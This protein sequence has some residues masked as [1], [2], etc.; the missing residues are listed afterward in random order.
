MRVTHVS[1]M[2]LVTYL[3]RIQ[4]ADTYRTHG[5]FTLTLKTYFGVFG[6]EFEYNGGTSRGG[7]QLPPLRN[8]PIN[9]TQP[10]YNSG[11]DLVAFCNADNQV[12]HHVNNG[13]SLARESGKIL[14]I[15]NVFT[16]HFFCMQMFRMECLVEPAGLGAEGSL[17]GPGSMLGL[18]VHSIIEEVRVRSR[19]SRWKGI[20]RRGRKF[21]KSNLFYFKYSCSKYTCIFLTMNV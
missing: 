7:F 3:T 12:F 5:V 10:R 20:E 1:G 13:L 17:T 4:A 6:A 11:A 8:C 16:T 21:V 18:G 2:C 19:V 9:N 14:Y 15:L